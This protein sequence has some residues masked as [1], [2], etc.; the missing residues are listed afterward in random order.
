MRIAQ[1]HQHQHCQPKDEPGPKRRSHRAQHRNEQKLMGSALT[2]EPGKLHLLNP[3]TC[4]KQFS[5]AFARGSTSTH[6][7]AQTFDSCSHSAPV[8]INI[9]FKRYSLLSCVYCNGFRSCH[10]SKH[11][12]DLDF[13]KLR[14]VRCVTLGIAITFTCKPHRFF[15]HDPTVDQRSRNALRMTRGVCSLVSIVLTCRTRNAAASSAADT[16]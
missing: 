9:H 2:M 6:L 13:V 11:R 15:L 8:H 1:T 3:S 4:V 5:L 10:V 16:S 14:S 7:P 12:I